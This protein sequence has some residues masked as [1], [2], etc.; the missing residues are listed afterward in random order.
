M[1]RKS[2]CVGDLFTPEFENIIIYQEEGKPLGRRQFLDKNEW[3]LFLGTFAEIRGP[4]IFRWVR[5]FRLKNKSCGLISES[6][7]FFYFQF[8]NGDRIE[9]V[10]I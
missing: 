3:L 2:I 4:T 7:L 8:P 10:C 9:N 1:K 6:D 5:F